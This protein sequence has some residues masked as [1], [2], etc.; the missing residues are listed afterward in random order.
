[1]DMTALTPALTGASI[2]ALISGGVVWRTLSV[3]AAARHVHLLTV[4]R[5]QVAA[6]TQSMRAAHARLQAE[7]TRE[8]STAQQ[9]HMAALAEQRASVTRLEG[10]LRF[11]Y[12]EIDRLNAA[13]L[14][15]TGLPGDGMTDGD[16][17]AVTRPYER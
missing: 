3:R 14:H 10:Q 2:G 9:R 17:F 4:A 13:N 8:R 6:Q 5:E 7:L 1:M 11:A 12:A 16:G 15:H